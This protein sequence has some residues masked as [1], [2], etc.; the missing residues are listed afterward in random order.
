MAKVATL[1]GALKLAKNK[2]GALA[3]I[4]VCPT[5]PLGSEIDA[6][7]ARRREIIA[8][9]EALFTS[10]GEWRSHTAHA[11]LLAV[12]EE[13]LEQFDNPEMAVLNRMH[14]E[15]ERSRR[16]LNATARRAELYQ[17][18]RSLPAGYSRRF[19]VLYKESAG[20]IGSRIGPA[21]DTLEELVAAL[22]AIEPGK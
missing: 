13:F 11:D 22:E 14:A 9:R 1:A 7:I 21:A 10:L 12:A 8:E 5:A 17:E 6:A 18:Q 16:I 4:D 19:M 20:S 2:Y 3:R 15:A